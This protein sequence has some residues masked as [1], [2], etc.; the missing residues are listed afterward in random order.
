MEKLKKIISS[1]LTINNGEYKKYIIH[2]TTTQIHSFY[3]RCHHSKFFKEGEKINL[4]YTKNNRRKPFVVFLNESQ[5][6]DVNKAKRNQT[7][8]T[9]L[10]TYK[11]L[12]KT[13][14]FII[15][16][17]DKIEEIK[18]LI[19][20]SRID[21][22]EDLIKSKVHK[23]KNKVDKKED[24][25]KQPKVDKK[26]D[27]IKQPKVHKSKKKV[28]KKEDLI[29]QPKVHK[30]KKKVDKKEDLIKQPKKKIKN[31]S[32]E[33]KEFGK[34]VDNSDYFFNYEKLYNSLKKFQSRKK[35]P[36][37]KKSIFDVIRLPSPL[38]I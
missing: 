7:K 17:N 15:K 36:N 21:K 26:E 14:P 38:K 19:K 32:S 28:D 18:K 5:I 6:K 20:K 27:L 16:I 2:L 35:K 33:D 22:K 30:S 8:Y 9:L 37:Q 12:K 3:F 25:I 11:Q 4:N 29:K 13:C 1:K 34:V 31:V 10:L 24:L 23:S